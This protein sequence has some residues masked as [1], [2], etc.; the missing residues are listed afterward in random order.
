MSVASSSRRSAPRR[1]PAARL[2]LPL[3]S[4]VR[5]APGRAR[6]PAPAPRDVL[7]AAV[8]RVGGAL[9]YAGAD[10]GGLAADAC[11]TCAAELRTVY[12]VLRS[13]RVVSAAG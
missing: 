5:A 12:R 6:S 13:V 1:S 11:A 4:P 2:P 7:L 9:A 10:G 8:A 3:P